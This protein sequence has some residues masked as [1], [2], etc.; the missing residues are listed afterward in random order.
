VS[1]LPQGATAPRGGGLPLTTVLA[2][3][4][5]AVP[6]AVLALALGVFLPR[7]FAGHIGISLV[8]VGAAFTIVR[9]IDIAFD[10]MIG[11]LMDRTRTPIGRYRPWVI[12]GAPVMMLGAYKLFNPPAGAGEGYLIVWLLVIYAALSIVSLAHA[13]WA[14]SIATS[15]DER[16]RVYG[17]MHAVG[18]AGAVGLLLLP[19]LTGGRIEPGSGDSMP[20]VGWIVILGIPLATA[21]CVLL[22]PEKVAPR[23]AAET[24]D[25]RE[26]W[27]ALKRPEMVRLILADL[28]LALG[29]GTT[30]AIYVFFFHDAKAFNYAQVSI[31]LVPFIGAGLLGAPVWAKLAQRFGK[32][33][34]LMGATVAYALFQ[35]IL[36]AIPKGLFL[37]TALGMFAVGFTASAFVVLVRAMVA[38]VGDAIRLEQGKEQTGLLYAMV[39]STQKVGAAISVGIIFPVLSLVGYNAADNVTNTPDAIFGLEMCYL[40]A[41]IIFVL[42]G[43]ACFF[44]YGMNAEKHAAIRAALDARDARDEAAT[45]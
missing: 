26:Y 31:L 4:S 3:S 13:A 18:V 16:S 20:A 40:F 35:T 39:T 21:L 45:A 14:S 6:L 8:A 17:W 38:D 42:I 1:A 27:Q 24:F 28:A 2:F 30:A 32:H 33:Q 43:G 41:P 37:P 10:P 9:L 22:A 34:T 29:P 7:Y 12:A 44:G 5:T 11:A 25:L 23:N 19:A 15:Y 36:M